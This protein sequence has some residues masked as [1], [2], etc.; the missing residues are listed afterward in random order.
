MPLKTTPKLIKIWPKNLGFGPGVWHS[1]VAAPTECYVNP[2]SAELRPNIISM[3]FLD[4]VSGG[5]WNPTFLSS[6]YHQKSISSWSLKLIFCSFE[7]LMS[8][9]GTSKLQNMSFKL[10]LLEPGW[11]PAGREAILKGK[12]K[13]SA[14]DISINRDHPSKKSDSILAPKWIQPRWSSNFMRLVLNYQTQTPFWDCAKPLCP[15]C[16]AGAITVLKGFC[17]IAATQAQSSKAG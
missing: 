2:N 14:I 1:G 9:M 15:A 12:T 4:A 10:Q 8:V 17:A 6:V 7:V 3:F 5:A 13:N 16:Y 11:R